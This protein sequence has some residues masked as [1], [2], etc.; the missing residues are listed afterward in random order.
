MGGGEEEKASGA[1]LQTLASPGWAVVLRVSERTISEPVG[2]AGTT[3]QPGGPCTLFPQWTP[4][5]PGSSV[6]P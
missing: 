3:R 5:G 6:N 1:G 4:P 2:V